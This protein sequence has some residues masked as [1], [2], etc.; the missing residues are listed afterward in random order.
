MDLQHAIFV[1]AEKT[2]PRDENKPIRL[3]LH[4]LLNRGEATSTQTAG[5]LKEIWISPENV[6]GTWNKVKDL[7]IGEVITLVP[8]ISTRNN[9][10][11]IDY[12]V[13]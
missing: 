13:E 7:V 6:S 1:K 3:I 10:D 2:N 4:V 9:R 12:E 11:Y 8:V 5:T